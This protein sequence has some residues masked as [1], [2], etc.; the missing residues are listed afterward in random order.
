VSEDAPRRRKE[1]VVS[2]TRVKRVVR[3][4]KP[5]R[6]AAEAPA[7]P[8]PAPPP[9]PDG[10]GVST[11]DLAPPP[12]TPEALA[13]DMDPA[14]AERFGP[15]S[16]LAAAS[17][18][19]LY[20]AL[21]RRS[22]RLTAVR[23]AKVGSKGAA[24][25][26]QEVRVL[27]HAVHM[28]LIAL[29]DHGVAGAQRWCACQY[30]EGASLRRRLDG[31]PLAPRKAALIVAQVLDGLAALHAAGWVHRD[32]TPERVRD[33][34]TGLYK[35]LGFACALPPPPAKAFDAIRP[36]DPRYAAP[37]AL[38]GERPGPLADVYAAGAVLYELVAGV[39]RF[40]GTSE[41]QLAAKLA[42]E[43]P[44]P[45]GVRVALPSGFDELVLEALAREPKNR[46]R[47]ASAMADALRAL[48]G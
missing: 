4:K 31:G 25:I 20:L 2:T 9:E 19:T 18:G 26:D 38:R 17:D 34:G 24:R 32:L 3:S 48:A 6:T 23:F 1:S 16:R 44:P 13:A 12:P 36:P 15:L 11:V 27:A 30:I 46:F 22:S 14:L 41:A 21:D 28:N 33:S 45:P 43:D 5:R 35:V 8:K 42:A 7:P 47:S 39:P 10:D 29:I 37:E 40:F